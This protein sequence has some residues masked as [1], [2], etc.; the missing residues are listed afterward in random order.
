[1]CMR[2]RERKRRTEGRKEEE[3]PSSVCAEQNEEGGMTNAVRC[4]RESAK[5][6]RGKDDKK[7]F[8]QWRISK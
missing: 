7:G 6:E 3:P 4:V 8:A 1:M 5:D 2:I